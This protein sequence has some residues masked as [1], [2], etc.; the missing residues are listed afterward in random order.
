MTN[1]SSC[2]V[3]DSVALMT[4]AH[5]FADAVVILPPFYFGPVSPDGVISFV[6]AVL[7]QTKVP[8]YLYNFTR[9]TQ[10]TISP[11]LLRA[12]A[13]QIALLKGIKD[14][15]PSVDSTI[16]LKT[17][18]PTLE[19]MSGRDDLLVEVYTANLDGVVAGG[20]NPFPELLCSI[21]DSV[22]TGHVERAVALQR[23]IERW[24][25]FRAQLSLSSI[26]AAKLGISTRIPGYSCNV[27]P[28]LVTSGPNLRPQANDAVSAILDDVRSMLRS[29]QQPPQLF[30][31]QS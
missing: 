20:F 10:F 3:A 28:P 19:V 22:I 27:R 14:S 16:A 12:L 31:L 30:S 11:E 7:K 23:V 21:G 24:K 6:S 15:D 4:H 8:S 26:A 9:Y 2:C 25:Q 29:W 5:E 13:V 18:N 17:L 1:I